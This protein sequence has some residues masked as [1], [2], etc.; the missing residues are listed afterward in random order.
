MQMK[1]INKELLWVSLLPRPAVA[2]TERDLQNTCRSLSTTCWRRWWR[3][4]KEGAEELLGEEGA[5]ELQLCSWI[6][7]IKTPLTWTHAMSI[8]HLVNEAA[9]HSWMECKSQNNVIFLENNVNLLYIPLLINSTY[10]PLSI[11]QFPY[12]L[13]GLISSAGDTKGEMELP[14]H[15]K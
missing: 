14:P 6:L 12:F 13:R 8:C 9:S 7:N 5:E 2:W 15:G 1:M 4:W 10:S 11:H 3:R